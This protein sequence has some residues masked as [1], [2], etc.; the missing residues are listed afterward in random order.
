MVVLATGPGQSCIACSRS[1][2]RRCGTM[3]PSITLR[4]MLQVG[5]V[6]QIPAGAGW[7]ESVP[8]AAVGEVKRAF[9]SLRD[10]QWG[11]ILPRKFFPPA[12]NP[13][14]RAMRRTDI[15]PGPSPLIFPVAED[16]ERAGVTGDQL[17]RRFRAGLAVV[18]DQDTGVRAACP[19]RRSGRFAQYAP[20]PELGADSHVPVLSP[21]V[22]LRVPGLAGLS[23]CGTAAPTM[24]P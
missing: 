17:G 21:R 7:A 14:S 5:Q 6:A 20:G 10:F 12:R 18:Q 16:R 13:A 24:E 23:R 2:Q 22:G 9:L 3:L 11:L 15:S 1:D 4:S 19:G 8:C